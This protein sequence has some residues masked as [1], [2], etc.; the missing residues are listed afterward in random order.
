MAQRGDRVVDFAVDDE[1]HE[2]FGLLEGEATLDEPE[3]H[4]R[5]LDAF[6]E[7]AF[8]EGEAELAVLED[9][10]RAGVVVLSAVGIHH[11][12]VSLTSSVGRRCVPTSGD[13][14]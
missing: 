9:I 4:R 7:V 10:V 1:V 5:L 14:G 11:L 12:G 3:L 2:V 13:Y 8:V 6:A